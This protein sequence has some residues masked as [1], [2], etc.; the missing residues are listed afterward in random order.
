ML[1]EASEIDRSL[2]LAHT[3]ALREALL[4]L[5]LKVLPG[6]PEALGQSNAARLLDAVRARGGIFCFRC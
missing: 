5:S 2:L 3:S 4:L 1:L 6:E